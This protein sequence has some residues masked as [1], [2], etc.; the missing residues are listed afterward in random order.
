ML[1][2]EQQEDGQEKK[3]FQ[4]CDWQADYKVFTCL[5]SVELRRTPLVPSL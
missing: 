2:K 1:D 4:Q 5:V 3:L